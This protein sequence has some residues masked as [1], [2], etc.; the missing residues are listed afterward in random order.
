MRLALR[1]TRAVPLNAS[2]FVNCGASLA[3]SGGAIEQR[4]VAKSQDLNPRRRFNKPPDHLAWD[5]PSGAEGDV[6]ERECSPTVKRTPT[7]VG[8]WGMGTKA[9]ATLSLREMRVSPI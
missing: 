2:I 6:G 1:L 9:G 4:F 3:P 7:S 8:C 5:K